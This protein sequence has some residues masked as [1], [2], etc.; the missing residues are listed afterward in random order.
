MLHLYDTLSDEK[1]PFVP[2]KEGEVSM[3]VCGVT[4][5]D[6]IHVGHLKS[7]VA[8]EVMR[9]YFENQGYAVTFVRNITDVDDKIIAKAQAQNLD[10]LALVNYYI[11]NFHQLVE[12]LNMRNPDIEPRVT[13]FL[14]QIDRYVQDLIDSGYAYETEDGIYFNTQKDKIEKY[15]LSKKIAQ[16]LMDESR[17]EVLYDKKHKADFALWKKDEEYGYLT[18]VFK[19]NKVAGRPG[20]HI[21]C[22][23]MHHYTLGKQFDIHGGGRDLIFPHHE[24]EIAQSQAH[25][26][27]SPANYWVHNGMMMKDGKKLSKSLG[28]SIYVKDLIE[29]YSPAALKLF[30]SKGHYAQSQEFK[31]NEIQEAD[32]RLNAFYEK[33]GS[34]KEVSHQPFWGDFIQALEDDF[35]TP[36]ALSVVYQNLKI[37][38]ETQSHTLAQELLEALKMLSVFP[39]EMTLDNLHQQWLDKQQYPEEIAKLFEQRQQ[40]KNNKDYTTADRIR[41]EILQAGWELRDEK[42]GKS[43][44]SRK[45]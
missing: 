5:Y 10:P 16:D 14:P 21:E 13:Q 38:N 32:N 7:M 22:S 2:L 45:M 26:A 41:Q 25:N 39:K 27:V 23:V 8:F 9:N 19:R 24:N 34:I 15:P 17:L 6:D 3:Y 12:Q 35:N 28:N 20:W 4:L 42:G 18:N 36:L 31:E 44:L 40:A 37:F 11:D 33:L 29:Q 30:L 1:K 43:Y